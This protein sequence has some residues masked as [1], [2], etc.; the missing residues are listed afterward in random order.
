MPRT[1]YKVSPIEDQS[2]IGEFV[3]T[4]PWSF[5]YHYNVIKPQILDN[6]ELGG[7]VEK[8]FVHILESE[9]DEHDG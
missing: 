8:C 7:A 2:H 3:Q 9:R 1:S 5:V 4:Q 6:A